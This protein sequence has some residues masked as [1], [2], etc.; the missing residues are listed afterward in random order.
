LAV[1]TELTQNQK[2]SEFKKCLQDPV[3][4]ISKYVKISH[5]IHG[6]P[7]DFNLFDYQEETVKNL[8]G[9]RF[10]IILKARQLGLTEICAAFSTW[11]L[12]FNRNK[13]VINTATKIGTAKNLI[14]KVH[15]ALDKLPKWMVSKKSADNPFVRIVRKNVNS[16]DLDNGSTMKSIPPTEDAGHSESVS[17]FIVDEAAKIHQLDEL[18]SGIYHSAQAGGNII[19]LSTPQ[20][21][22]GKFYEIYTAAE[23]GKNEFRHMALPWWVHPEHIIDVNGKFD[24]EDDPDR[25]GKKTSSWFRKE[26][27]TSNLSPS[28][29]AEQLEISFIGSGNTVIPQEVIDKIKAGCLDPMQ[30]TYMDGNYWIWQL[31]QQDVRYMISCDVARG[32]A[33]DFDAAVVWRISDMAQVAEYKGQIKAAEFANLVS[34]MG[35]EYNNALLVIENAGV[36]WSVLEHLKLLEYPNI[37]FSKQGYPK[38]GQAI[39]MKWGTI[40]SDLKPGF[41]VSANNRA[42]LIERWDEYIRTD[43]VRFVSNRMHNEIQTFIW[44]DQRKAEARKGCNDDLVMASAIGVWVR[45]YFIATAHIGVEEH[46]ATLLNG[47]S[48]TIV[49]H[50]SIAGASK[51]PNFV[52]RSSLGVFIDSNLRDNPQHTGILRLPNKQELDI[53]WVMNSGPRKR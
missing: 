48:Q 10:N 43:R 1:K 15:Y 11:L 24:L 19:L 29:V 38:E 12:V 22:T 28:Q 8:L 23:N 41:T 36:G 39:N 33:L 40:D 25:P 42:I 20:G 49:S 4:F 21:A 9:H 46:K 32:D 18:W 5:P 13:K 34:R 50:T 17:L 31:P 47:L 3:H 6:K 51:D 44:S 14:N 30:R 45:E 2:V 35:K 7:L 37:Y 26:V 16:I 53:S 52:P 27:K